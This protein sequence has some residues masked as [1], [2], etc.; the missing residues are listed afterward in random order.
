MSHIFYSIVQF[1]TFFPKLFLK[2]M[3]IFKF[4][5]YIKSYWFFFWYTLL[6]ITYILVYNMHFETGKLVKFYTGSKSCSSKD[7]YKNWDFCT[8]LNRSWR[9]DYLKEWEYDFK[10]LVEILGNSICPHIV[11]AYS[12]VFDIIITHFIALHFYF[13]ATCFMVC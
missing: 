8:E 1:F 13:C 4:N 7:K 6:H 3:Y 5:L 2:E 9:H 12:F 11:F 10:C